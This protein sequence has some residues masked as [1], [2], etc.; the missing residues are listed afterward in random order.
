MSLLIEEGN[1]DDVTVNNNFLE[2]SK[3]VA[4]YFSTLYWNDLVGND[5]SAKSPELESLDKSPDTTNKVPLE[6]ARR[7]KEFGDG[8]DDAIKK[9]LERTFKELVQHQSIWDIDYTQFSTACRSVLST[10]KDVIQSGWVQMYIVYNGIGRLVTELRRQRQESDAAGGPGM[11]VSQMEGY[12]GNFM[13]DSGLRAWIEQQGGLEQIIRPVQGGA[14][15]AE[16]V[17][18]EV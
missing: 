11:R 15:C 9:E 6:V 8:I 10:C 17:E 13:S 1:V 16:I 14:T 4:K 12:A 2:E 5:V 18:S 7:L 3:E